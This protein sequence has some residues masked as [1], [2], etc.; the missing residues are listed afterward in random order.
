[1]QHEAWNRRDSMFGSTSIS[2]GSEPTL[3][4]DF[5]DERIQKDPSSPG[6]FDATSARSDTFIL[7]IEKSRR[8]Q[9]DFSRAC[10]EIG[11]L[12]DGIKIISAVL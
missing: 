11:L 5:S 9:N 8:S 1:M 12:S 2:L 4:T 6:R 10:R 7:R 3:E